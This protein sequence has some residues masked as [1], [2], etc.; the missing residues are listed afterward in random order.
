MARRRGP[1]SNPVRRIKGGVPSERIYRRSMDGRDTLEGDLPWTKPL[2][3]GWP[4]D[5]QRC[6]IAVPAALVTFNIPWDH[7]L[8]VAD[9]F[10]RHQHPTAMMR[11]TAL[12]IVLSLFTQ[13]MLAAPC[14]HVKGSGNVV[15]K[16]LSV[17]AFHGIAVDGSID[18]VLTPSGNQQV[19]VE[20]QENLIG[21]VTTEVRNGVWVIG[22]SKG[23]STDKPFVVHIS[24][25]VIDVVS[26]GG[27]GN[28]KGTGAFTAGWVR[29]SVQGSG[30]MDLAFI[31]GAL[32][33]SVAG[34]G[35]IKLEGRCTDLRV[36]VQGSGE[37]N[38]KGM[39]AENA[40]AST[41]GSGDIS[42]HTS[43]RLDASVAGSG[44]V[45][46]EG[47]P[48]NVSTN[49]AGSGEVRAARTSGKL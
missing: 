36:L 46:Y 29:L 10:V 4:E 37:I 15:R 28:V 11:A 33:A 16:V 12:F 22:T 18:V 49:V 47:E 23:Y 35:D 42:V 14:V 30:D 38:A 7:L 32:D 21:L 2:Q 3:R 19:E 26:I 17:E 9:S 24:A 5:A 13:G 8:P 43:G 41:S 45:V 6:T 25:P 40:S 31:S 34:S 39:V 27:S 48:A 20:A 44:D 1:T